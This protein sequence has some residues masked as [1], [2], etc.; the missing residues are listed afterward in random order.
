MEPMEAQINLDNP[1]NILW[2]RF[3]IGGRDKRRRLRGQD[4]S[5]ETNLSTGI[6][7]DFSFSLKKNIEESVSLKKNIEESFSLK[8]NVRGFEIKGFGCLKS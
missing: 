5:R 7:G 1:I 3:T 4:E 8:K 6:D 2:F